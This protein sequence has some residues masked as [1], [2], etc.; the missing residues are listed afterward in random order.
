MP[1]VELTE[2]RV[3]R[4]T[5]T[6]RSA[7]SFR[8]RPA[9]FPGPRT[10]KGCTPSTGS[11]ASGASEGQSY[12]VGSTVQR[13]HRAKRLPAG[14]RAPRPC[15]AA[16]PAQ[17]REAGHRRCRSSGATA[18]RPESEDSLPVL[19]RYDGQRPLA[20]WLIRV[21]Q[22]WHLSKLRQIERR[23]RTSRMTKS[24]CR[25]TPRS[26]TAATAGTTRLLGAAREVAQLHSTT[27]SG[28][29]SWGFAGVT[30]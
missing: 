27:R 6:A 18:Y 9:G 30:G 22:N 5:S 3:P 12:R 10:S 29:C 2:V 14:G 11:C 8:N 24:R 28:S 25:W 16:L 20:P 21:F 7:S 4:R 17:R 19:A 13:A 26:P 15:R 1:A 23:D